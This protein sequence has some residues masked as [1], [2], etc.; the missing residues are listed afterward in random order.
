MTQSYS[1]PDTPIS[2][3]PKTDTVTRRAGHF[4]FK[5]TNS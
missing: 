3:I 2:K 1:I 4:A 5:A